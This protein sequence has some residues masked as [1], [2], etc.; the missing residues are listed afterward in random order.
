MS[1]QIMVVDDD[2]TTRTLL[3]VMLRR[4]GY[5]VIEVSNA[6]MAHQ[7]LSTTI[8]DLIILDVMLPGGDGFTFCRELRDDETTA[9]VPVVM[10][11]ARHD[12]RSIA[13]S[14]EVGAN[15]YLSKPVLL[16]QLTRTVDHL[17]NGARL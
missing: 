8:P 2:P 4:G 3:S 1:K 10:L 6:R 13:R 17:L 7:I 12:A 11:S 5:S 15:D 16:G 9:T 14:I